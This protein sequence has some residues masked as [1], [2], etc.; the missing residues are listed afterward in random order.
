[1]DK[2]KKSFDSLSSKEFISIFRKKSPEVIKENKRKIEAYNQYLKNFN[3]ERDI[4]V[5]KENLDIVNQIKALAGMANK[6]DQIHATQ[7]DVS[8]KVTDVHARLNGKI[9]ENKKPLTKKQ[10]DE[11]IIDALILNKQNKTRLNGYQH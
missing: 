7:S 8:S 11:A 5:P 6:V 10:R 1:M 2:I 4:I 9:C 3:P